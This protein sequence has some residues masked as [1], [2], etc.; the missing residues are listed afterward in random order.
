MSSKY[1]R[2]FLVSEDE[3]DP[4]DPSMD[5]TGEDIPPEDS[6][7][8]PEEE[9]EL[10]IPDEREEEYVDDDGVPHNLKIVDIKPR[11]YHFF[12]VPEDAPEEDI[13]PDEMSDGGQSLLDADGNPIE[14]DNDVPE[15]DFSDDVDQSTDDTQPEPDF[16]DD[17]GEEP[18]NETPP[19][20][21]FSDDN[22]NDED[23]EPGD[24]NDVPEPDFSTDN[25]EPSEEEIPE[26]DF[27]DDSTS[28]P[29][30]MENPPEELPQPPEL[31][32]ED[33]Q[34]DSS[35]PTPDFSDLGGATDNTSGAMTAD[36]SQQSQMPM[37][38]N[39]ANPMDQSAPVP[40][41]SQTPAPAAPTPDTSMNGIQ[42]QPMGRPMDMNMQTPVNPDGSPS[43]TPDGSPMPS[44]TNPDGTP[45]T[46]PD[47][48]LMAPPLNPDGSPMTNPD[49][50]PMA[51]PAGD[52]SVDNGPVLDDMG[53]DFSPNDNG[54]GNPDEMSGDMSADAGAAGGEEAP[55]APQGPGLE[56]NSTRKYTLF[57]NYMS[58]SN[59]I[60]NYISKLELQMGEDANKTAV[61]KSATDKLRDI[62]DLCYDYI[63]MK[64]EISSYVQSLLFFQKMIV[65]IQM[66]FEMVSETNK[67]TNKKQD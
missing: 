4:I 2:Y 30:G 53:S 47:G 5:D 15:P 60:D 37:D 56:Y 19:E 65:M 57:K 35:T 16:S 38:T 51:Q 66:V 55:Q 26:P 43:T 40:D 7:I 50:T 3:M 10:Y 11:N 21:D 22:S 63:T 28:N 46:N 61:L 31:G 6:E 36:M 54:G 13:I 33:I 42:A 64:F 24:D 27:S 32:N 20:P 58:L 8:P 48:S 25:E 23:I 62:N 67:K 39:G 41:F 9:E 45:M 1:G 17:S 49:G 12:S 18:S 29:N 44:P 34:Q 59:A 14:D 52:M